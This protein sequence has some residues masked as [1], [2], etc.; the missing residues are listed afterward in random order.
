MIKTTLTISPATQLKSSKSY[1]H[2]HGILEGYLSESI[3]LSGEGYYYEGGISGANEFRFNHA[4][5][6]K[7]FVKN[8]LDFYIGIQPGISFTKIRLNS[9]ENAGKE[10]MGTNPSFSSVVG[11]NYFVGKYVHFFIQSRLVLSHHNTD[12]YRSINELKFSGGL[13]FNINTLK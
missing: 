1:F 3:S 2:L 4:G 7:H 12:V 9:P 5:F 10:K 6:S 13:G 11:V 8:N